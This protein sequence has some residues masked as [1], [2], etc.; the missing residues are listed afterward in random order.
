[1]DLVPPS[2]RQRLNSLIQLSSI[3]GIIAFAALSGSFQFIQ[4]GRQPLWLGVLLLGLAV[5]LMGGA[6][7]IAMLVMYR[8]W[9]LRQ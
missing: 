4:D 6:M 9:K 7:A 1:M 3:V 5:L 2:Q 8:T